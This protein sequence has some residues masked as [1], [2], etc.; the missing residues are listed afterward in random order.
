MLESEGE[1][2]PELVHDALGELTNMVGGNL[3]AMFGGKCHLGLPQVSDGDARSQGSR[4]LLR[5]PF[6]SRGMALVVEV[7]AAA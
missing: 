4:T 2:G 7:A 5:V 3:K 6:A 1:A